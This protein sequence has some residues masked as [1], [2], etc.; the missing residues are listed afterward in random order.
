MNE[1]MPPAS[2]EAEE[3]VLGAILFDP[4]AIG[5]L[6]DWLPI[7]AFYV[8]NH[9]VIYRAAIY[10]TNSE[11]G[12][13]FITL[14]TY[15]SDQGQ[16][17]SIGGTAQLAQLLNQTVS[18]V[19]CD[20]Y[21]KLI[22][23]KYQRRELIAFGYQI[24]EMG[25]DQTQELEAIYTKIKELLP[26]GVTGMTQEDKQPKITKARYTVISSSG[27]HKIELEADIEDL[28]LDKAISSLKDDC[29]GVA[30]KLWSVGMIFP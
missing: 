15:L 8:S 17:D 2:I 5:V 4:K 29:E 9:R 30:E 10:L 11:K 28:D 20:R 3:A 25:Y 6:K 16:L 12:T 22:L 18:A 14:S 21:G 13:D 23:E 24:A 26:P 19:N 7:E 27:Q 1:Q